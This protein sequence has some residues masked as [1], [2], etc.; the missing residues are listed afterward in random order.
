MVKKKAVSLTEKVRQ[1]VLKEYSR[2]PG[3]DYEEW[4][5]FIR[6]EVDARLKEI[7]EQNI[8]FFNSQKQSKG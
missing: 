2:I 6:Y 8:K 3:E 5:E 7:N 4:C 1:E